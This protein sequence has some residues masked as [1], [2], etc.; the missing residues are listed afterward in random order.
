MPSKKK[1]AQKVDKA[2]SRT[3]MGIE[4]HHK[5]A[6]MHHAKGEI[7]RAKARLLE[8]QSPKKRDTGIIGRY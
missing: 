1:P 6:D 8:A 5:M 7:H 3:P 2:K 4:D